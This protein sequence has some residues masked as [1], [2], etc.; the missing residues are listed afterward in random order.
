MSKQNIISPP[1]FR[2][3]FYLL[4]QSSKDIIKIISKRYDIE[5]YVD[6]LDGVP[7][8]EVPTILNESSILLLLTNTSVGDNTPK[9]IMG[10]KVFEYIAVEKPILC[11]RNDQ[12]CLEETINKTKS[13]ISA[14]SVEEVIKF[15]LEKYAEWKNNGFT[16]QIIDKKSIELFSRKYQSKQFVELFENL[17]LEA[18]KINKPTCLPQ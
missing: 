6:I 1:K 16:Q 8:S 13:G 15:I 11:V 4:N 9:G 2:L 3:Q 5:E 12:S 17:L 7:N 14:S 10:T 18:T